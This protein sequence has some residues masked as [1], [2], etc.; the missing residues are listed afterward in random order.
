MIKNILIWG[1]IFIAN[2]VLWIEGNQNNADFSNVT[3][4]GLLSLDVSIIVSVYLVQCLVSK[5]R[6]YDYL[7]KLLDSIVEDIANPNIVNHDNHIKASLLQRYISNKLLYIFK[8]VPKKAKEDMEYVKSTFDRIQTYYGDHGNAS[9]DDPFYERE[10][11]NICIKV[12][13]VQLVLYG[14]NICEK[15]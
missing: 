6:K 14:Y 2:I 15:N 12:A 10:M 13:K 11:I 1:G 7:N 5:R 9:V 3:I 4:M 8:A